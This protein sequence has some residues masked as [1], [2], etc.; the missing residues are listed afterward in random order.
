MKYFLQLVFVILLTAGAD[1]LVMDIS[2]QELQMTKS[3]IFDW[4]EET[5]GC[6]LS[7]HKHEGVIGKFVNRLEDWENERK[8][9]ENGQATSYSSG[10]VDLEPSSIT[11]ERHSEY[12]HVAV[13]ESQTWST[14]EIKSADLARNLTGWSSVEKD[15]VMHVN[16]VRLYPRKYLSIVVLPWEMPERYRALDKSTSYYRGLVTELSRVQPMRAVVPSERL[17]VSADCFA[18]AQGERGTTGHNRW[19]TGCPD[20][21]TAENCQYGMDSGEDI[22]MRLL[23]DEGVTSLGHR[24]NLLNAEYKKIGVGH[25]AHKKYGK[26]TVQELIW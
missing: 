11:N 4:V 14:V 22:V 23:I 1:M 7:K 12:D 21:N 6:S 10:T 8:E 19:S 15:V 24:K 13:S 5:T 9:T 17:K 26:V 20:L 3:K 2:T 18:K 25:A 16:L